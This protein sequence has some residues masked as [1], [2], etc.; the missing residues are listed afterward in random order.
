MYDGGMRDSL[1]RT[2]KAPNCGRRLTELCGCQNPLVEDN[3][4]RTASDP[5]T[6]PTSISITVQGVQEAT[7]AAI[8]NAATDATASTTPRTWGWALLVAV[9]DF[10]WW[11]HVHDVDGWVKAAGLG[12]RRGSVLSEDTAFELP[13]LLTRVPLVFL[14]C[15]HCARRRLGWFRSAG[16]DE[17]RRCDSDR[18]VRGT[19]PAL[20]ERSND[21]TRAKVQQ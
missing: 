12:R 16:R 3:D 8:S 10:L 15:R 4:T 6:V 19:K 5:D 7:I 2:P 13:L 11:G 14:C 9:F 20:G 17:T 21:E 18:I 1:S